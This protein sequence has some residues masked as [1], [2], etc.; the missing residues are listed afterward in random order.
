[1]VML[2]FTYKTKREYWKDV[3]T[4]FDN[5]WQI[6]KC[7]IYMFT[8]TMEE[9]EIIQKPLLISRVSPAYNIGTWV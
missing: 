3:L 7:N 6:W 9:T 2:T 4:T 1:M 5:E 8:N